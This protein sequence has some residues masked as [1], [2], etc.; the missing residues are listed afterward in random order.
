MLVPVLE[1]VKDSAVEEKSLNEP[2]QK[3]DHKGG[4]LA[5]P[6]PQMNTDNQ[7]VLICVYLFESVANSSRELPS[8]TVGLL[9]LSA[10]RQLR[11]TR[12]TAE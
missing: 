3:P 7:P 10:A 4:Q 2:C 1:G 5:K 8:L 12:C 11:K 9:T 6:T